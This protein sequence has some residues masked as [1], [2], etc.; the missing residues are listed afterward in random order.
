MTI[1]IVED[2]PLAAR[3][4]QRLLQEAGYEQ[5]NMVFTEGIDETVRWLENH[6]HPDLI[7]QDIELADGNC[8]EIYERVQVSSPIIFTTAYHEHA[9]RAFEL[10]SIDYLLKPIEPDGLLRALNKHRRFATPDETLHLQA[11]LKQI[12]G[13]PTY[14]SHL[15]VNKGDELISLPCLD[16]AWFRAEEKMVQLCTHDNRRFWLN[17]SL[18]ELQKALNPY[19]F[20]RCNRALLA[21]RN[22]IAKVELHFHGKLKLE[23]IPPCEQTDGLT[24]SRERVA[25][26]KTWLGA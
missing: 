11:L 17:Q 3:R 4:M 12:A 22:A 19:H 24:V 6:P 21:Q 9:L 18:D 20:F 16:L 8:F 7:F 2:E 23:L 26:F 5:A 1:L 15:L 25:Q 10:N 13:A 14:R